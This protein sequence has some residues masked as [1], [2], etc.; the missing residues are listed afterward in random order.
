MTAEERFGRIERNLEET[1][2]IVRQL[3]TIAE[4]TLTKQDKMEELLQWLIRTVQFHERRLDC[5]EG[6]RPT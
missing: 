5:V 4:Q 3:A 1:G 6:T 2:R